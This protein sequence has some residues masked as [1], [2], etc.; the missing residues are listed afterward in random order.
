MKLFEWRATV[1]QPIVIHMNKHKGLLL[2]MLYQC[3]TVVT[4]VSATVLLS[5]ADDNGTGV[6]TRLRITAPLTGRKITGK[7]SVQGNA[8]PGSAITLVITST[9]YEL[10]TDQKK[11]KIFKGSGPLTGSVK[12]IKLKADGQG[13]WR[14]D[15]IDFRN[16]GWSETFKIVVTS[17]EGKNST[18]VLVT[19]ETKPVVA[20]D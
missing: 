19:N 14:I 9:Y 1:K 10:G 7:V 11:R 18:Y 17:V 5:R 15:T 13:F 16:R 6:D 2:A 8:K 20:W 4:P 3:A 12:K